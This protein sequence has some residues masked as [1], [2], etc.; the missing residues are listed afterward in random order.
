MQSRI[1][2]QGREP[3]IDMK[4]EFITRVRSATGRFQRNRD[5][6]FVGHFAIA[7]EELACWLVFDEIGPEAKDAAMRKMLGPP[8]KDPAFLKM[9]FENPYTATKEQSSE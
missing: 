7:G 2:E 1:D 6:Q 3:M 4:A 8:P 5:G 9:T